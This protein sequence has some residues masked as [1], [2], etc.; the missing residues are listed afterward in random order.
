MLVLFVTCSCVVCIYIYMLVC[1]YFSAV[2]C[3]IAYGSVL[4]IVL[5]IWCVPGFC[6]LWIH[7]CFVVV[8][9]LLHKNVCVM[10]II[11]RSSSFKVWIPNYIKWYYCI[12]TVTLQTVSVR[13]TFH[14]CT[15][16]VTLHT[17][18]VTVILLRRYT[19]HYCI[20]QLQLCYIIAQLHFQFYCI[21]TVTV[22]VRLHHCIAT[23]Q[24]QLHYIIA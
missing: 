14:C 11:R 7:I 19:F 10:Q 3:S 21:V 12:V 8:L 17:V 20:F 18:S 5:Y 6:D 1:K 13:V 16:T 4:Y 22:T 2:W 15:D 23:A 24:L 9:C